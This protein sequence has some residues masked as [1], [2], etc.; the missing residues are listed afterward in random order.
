MSG[1]TTVVMP[2]REETVS[3]AHRVIGTRL[4]KADASPKTNGEIAYAADFWVPGMLYAKVVRSSQ[5]SA[6]IRVDVTRARAL[7]G[8][9]AVLTAADVPHNTI[10][11]RFGQST[12]LG[13]QFEGLYRVLAEDHVRYYGEPVAL[14][15]AE[16]RAVAEQAAALVDIDY[17]PLPGVYDPLE[18]LA[19]DAPRVGGGDSNVVAQF[20]VV[21][22]DVER[23]FA[24]A[25]V[26][27]SHTYRVPV[28]DHAYMEPEAGEAWLD[29]NG[30]VVVR[31]ATQVIEHSR[32]LAEILGLPQSR[33]RVVGTWVGGGFGGKED[34]TVEAFLALIAWK[35]GRPVKLVFSRR[36]SFVGHG[37]RHAFVMRYRTGATRDGRLV[38]VEADLVADAG[39]YVTLTPWVLLYATANAVGPY[40]V[41]H[42][43]VRTR[44][45][46]T[47]N[48]PA[49]AFRGFGAVQPNV[50]H[51][52]QMDEVAR[53]LGWSPL[54]LRRR[55]YIRPG[56][57]LAHG[58]VYDRPVPL[59]PMADAVWAQLNQDPVP[60]DL[61]AHVR[62]G[63][64][65]AVSMTS[66]GRLMFLRDTA[67]SWIRL[68]PD[69]SAIVRCGVQD[70]GGG[71]VAS[72]RFIVSEEL[73]VPLDRIEVYHA[74]TAL[75]PL[76][77]TTTA[78][79]QLYMSGR[80]TLKAAQTLKA[81]VAQKA[82]AMLGCAAE[83]VEFGEGFV[84]SAQN[85]S[86]RVE[87]RTVVYA[88]YHDG[89]EM[90]VEAQ[91]NAPA[92]EVPESA[93]LKTP[94]FPDYTFGV[95]GVE[96][97]VNTL[98]GQVTVRRMVS[99]LDVGTAIN[100]LNV[101]GQ[102][103]GG[104]VQSLGYALWERVT[105]REG[106]MTSTTFGE[107]LIPTAS[108]IPDIETL[109]W[110]SGSGEGPYGAKGVGEPACN[111]VA[112]AVLNAIRDAVGVRVT[113]LP[114][115][116]EVVARTLGLY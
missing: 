9:Q 21:R 3:A 53:Q 116:A 114:A 56:S 22:G 88:C 51:E 63:R 40:E 109:I 33:V 43:R 82:A 96:V 113:A 32:D 50:A 67:R 97:A 8:V 87:L 75:T 78:T 99:A 77:G 37:K 4:A 93:T 106:I 107:Y 54:D 95:Q 94:L 34:I 79:R 25:D 85:P 102:M 57:T 62:V 64:G 83:D 115:N 92:I 47:N 44:A 60:T 28:I 91:F 45:V 23:G 69:G 46:L 14:V 16:S 13:R 18:A 30:V 84:W 6:R 100:L 65:L 110:E 104:A 81:R 73:G 105:A 59:A 24:E 66:Y 48:C 58:Q 80:A 70:I 111:A 98:T 17:D 89:E 35:T 71:Q 31:A 101:E 90:F 61:P 42:V 15:A 103:E 10:V 12:S 112:P 1:K 19:D 86:Q 74:D 5:A 29:D 2:E 76:A 55:N 39:A 72:L 41:P 27:V 108:D 49:S 52:S 11:S 68:E 38:A 26:T 20:E 36:E 7:P